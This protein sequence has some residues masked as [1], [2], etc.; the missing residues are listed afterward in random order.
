[1]NFLDYLELIAGVV[2]IALVAT[3]FILMAIGMIAGPIIAIIWAIS[4]FLL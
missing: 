1:M 2:A 3:F 4:Y